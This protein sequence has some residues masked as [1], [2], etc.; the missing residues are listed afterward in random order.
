M[1]KKK[2]KKKKKKDLLISATRYRC[3][4]MYIEQIPARTGRGLIFKYKNTGSPRTAPPFSFKTYGN[5]CYSPVIM[6]YTRAVSEVRGLE[7]VRRCYAEGG[8]DCY[9]KW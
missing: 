7:A 2:K 9:A 4:C 5:S 6:K 1:R 8:C 3:Y